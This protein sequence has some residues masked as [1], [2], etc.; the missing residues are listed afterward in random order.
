MTEEKIFFRGNPHHLTIL[1][2][3]A[4]KG[5]ISLWNSFVRKNGSSFR[6]R[7][8][9]ADLS[10]LSLPEIRLDGADLTDAD[11]SGAILTRANLSNA[12][13]RG[14]CLSGTDLTAARLNHT[15]LTNAD[16]SRAKMVNIRARG[17]LLTGSN[18]S[19]TIMDG[20]DLSKASMNGASV[21][22]SSR[23]GAR[24]KVRVKVKS[25]SEKK[26]D[27]VRGD[28]PWRNALKEEVQRKELREN[29]EELKAEEEKARLDRK[30]GRRKP[31]FNRVK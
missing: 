29:K 31:I 12:R 18:L 4:R 27:P 24:M 15:D 13:L 20:A 23:S 16:L 7:L 2:E 25:N 21:T 11:L 19:E 28:K 3:A 26:G 22:G 30:L 8:A 9:G 14:C 6:A 10:G 17:A 1:I 5:D